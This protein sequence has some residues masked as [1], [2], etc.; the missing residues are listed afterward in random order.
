VRAWAGPPRLS[1]H[2]L[3]VPCAPHK[4]VCRCL[5]HESQAHCYPLTQQG[6]LRSSLHELAPFQCS[7]PGINGKDR[8]ECARPLAHS[9][10]F[11]CAVAAQW[12][13]CFLVGFQVGAAALQ[14]QLLER[15]RGRA[16]RHRG[17]LPPAG[18]LRARAAPLWACTLMLLSAC[19]CAGWKPRLDLASQSRATA[20]CRLLGAQCP[21]PWCG[22]RRSCLWL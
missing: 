21:E 5:C 18:A 11:G 10:V 20:T 8:P 22:G 15:G 16:G 17:L 13:A 9:G 4:A 12:L 19:A 14:G 7:G 6:S 1:G 3:L 2:I